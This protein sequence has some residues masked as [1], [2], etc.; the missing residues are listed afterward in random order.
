[1]VIK[2]LI[3]GD[4][5]LSDNSWTSA[6]SLWPLGPVLLT[7]RFFSL[8]WFYL[9]LVQAVRNLRFQPCER[10]AHLPL[11]NQRSTSGCF[12]LE[13]S[14]YSSL[15]ATLF[16]KKGRR[17][18][19]SSS[20]GWLLLPSALSWSLSFLSFSLS[21]CL[22]QCQEEEEAWGLKL[23]LP[24]SSRKNKYDYGENCVVLRARWSCVIKK[25]RNQAVSGWAD[26]N[27]KHRIQ[28]LQWFFW[29][30][31]PKS[32]A[33]AGLLGACAELSWITIVGQCSLCFSYRSIAAWQKQ[34]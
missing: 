2:E 6:M 32:P 7:S 25:G 9:R 1:M 27:G 22:I 21:L 12:F 20:S 14:S 18:H 16:A 5:V 33:S 3:T 4:P 24:Y 10:D 29:T 28:D 26:V 11:T 34:E 17:E 30:P 31:K 19:K 15:L 8:I 23:Q 13:Y